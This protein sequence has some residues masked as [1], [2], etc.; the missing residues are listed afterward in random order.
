MPF[1]SLLFEGPVPP[2][3]GDAAYL[4]DL[5]LDQLFAVVTAG[6]EEYELDPFFRIPLPDVAAVTRRQ[7]V[8][9]DLEG[10]GLRTAVTAFAD[11][12]RG[13]RQELA[14]ADRLHHELQKSAL[15]LAAA[16]RYCAEVSGLGAA[17]DGLDLT[18]VA[19][20]DLRR[21]LTAHRASD[22]FRLLAADVRDCRERLAAIVY[23]VHIRGR[24]V[25]VR[26]HAGEPDYS[27]A[28]ERDF[29]KFKQGAAHAPRRTAAAD[30][31]H[32]GRGD[33]IVVTKLGQAPVAGRPQLLG[34]RVFGGPALR[35]DSL[36]PAHT[37]GLRLP[38][39]RQQ[40]RLGLQGGFERLEVAL[41][42]GARRSERL[43]VSCRPTAVFRY[44]RRLAGCSPS[45]RRT[46]PPTAASRPATS[47]DVQPRSSASQPAIRAFSD[48]TS[49]SSAFMS[50]PSPGKSNGSH[51]TESV[52]AIGAERAFP[53]RRP[54]VSSI[55][56]PS[57]ESGSRRPVNAAGTPSGPL[58]RAGS[59]MGSAGG[60]HGRVLDGR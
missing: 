2:E 46:F 5:N 60:G 10:A 44:R 8:M 25:T 4:T 22:E 39:L 30:R 41:G 11:G 7:A 15:F 24:R 40:R 42:G 54:R 29:A 56:L 13:V 51:R 12:M 27:A 43:S 53:G 28:V 23:S 17:L 38:A 58:A 52:G 47:A 59:W 1:E 20:R 18:S 16:E 31:P 35:H 32:R 19:L 37:G 6:R 45:R 26:Q 21:Y 33:L 50:G 34:G 49:A 48:T 57:K 9:R 55:T 36:G 14:G 3:P